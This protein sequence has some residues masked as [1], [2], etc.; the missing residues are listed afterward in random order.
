MGRGLWRGVLLLLGVWLLGAA[1]LHAQSSSATL[2]AAGDIG[3]CAQGRPVQTAAL[4][5]AHTGIILTLG[6]T[7]YPY[8]A[9]REFNDCFAPTWGR[10]RARIRPVPGNHDYYTPGAAGYYGYFGAAATPRQP[11]C[12]ADC[13]GYYAYT[14][15]EWRVYALNSERDMAAGSAQVAWLQAELAA[16]PAACILAYWHHPRFSSGGHGGDVRSAAIWEALS[17][18]GAD[19]VLVGH[20]HHYE[21]FAPQTPAGVADGA[22]GIRQFVVGTGGAPLHATQQRAAHSEVRRADT[23]G[24]LRLTLDPTRYAWEFVP[25]DG[26]SFTDSGQGSCIGVTDAMTQQLHLP[27]ITGAAG[28]KGPE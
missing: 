3:D 15:G 6:D 9:A 28:Q 23:W 24:V 27:L 1:P 17:A 21:R 26:G 25:V 12:V 2:L 22:T 16:H 4:L 14:L 19:L 7:T 11:D 18:A 13:E 20:D 5:D 10:H 8:G